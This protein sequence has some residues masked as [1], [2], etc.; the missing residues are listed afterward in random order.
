MQSKSLFWL[1]LCFLCLPLACVH[2]KPAQ[3]PGLE[4]QVRQAL[5]A[6][7]GRVVTRLKKLKPSAEVVQVLQQV[8]LSTKALPYLRGRA[9]VSLRSFDKAIALKTYKLLLS[10]PKQRVSLQR[11][12]LHSLSLLDPAAAVPF[13]T[14]ALNAKDTTLREAAVRA[15]V[16]A[17]SKQTLA[18]L[19]Q[20][21][22]IETR[23][24]IKRLL[25]AQI[26]RVQQQIQ[27]KQPQTSTP[28]QP[29]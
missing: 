12:T 10:Q 15:L 21:Q 17:P 29:R 7:H 16:R 27:T 4:K 3:T 5:R 1:G 2:A 23:A 28:A 14:Q 13:A 25:S 26:L 22:T 19:K 8:A 9:V 20:R 24:S 6:R 11:K 18:T